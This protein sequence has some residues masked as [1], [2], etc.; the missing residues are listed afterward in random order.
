MGLI[1]M[2]AQLA[3]AKEWTFGQARFCAIFPDGDQ[4]RMNIDDDAW[5]DFLSGAS[6]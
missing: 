3:S 5:L 1:F 4:I 2:V 6:K